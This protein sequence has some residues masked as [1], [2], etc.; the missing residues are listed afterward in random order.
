MWTCTPFITLRPGPSARGRH[1]NTAVPLGNRVRG[2]DLGPRTDR[3][4]IAITGSFR[5]L[6]HPDLRYLKV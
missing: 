5:Y 2:L 4:F 3:L 6:F 1:P